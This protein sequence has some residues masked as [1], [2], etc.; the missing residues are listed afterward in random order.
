MVSRTTSAIV[1]GTTAAPAPAGF[2]PR[3]HI[4]YLKSCNSN[5]TRLKS[6]IL[7]IVQIQLSRKLDFG[8]FKE[9]IFE[10]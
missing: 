2:E 1:Y 4:L 7:G 3:M 8:G 6:N 5:I 10:K 9:D